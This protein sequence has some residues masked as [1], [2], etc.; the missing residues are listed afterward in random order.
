MP[1]YTILNNDTGLKL[2][3]SHSSHHPQDALLAQFSLY[4]HKSGLS[5]DSFHYYN[6]RLSHDPIFHEL[7]THVACAQFCIFGTCHSFIMFMPKFKK[8]LVN[9]CKYVDTAF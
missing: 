7:V 8:K 9:D 2:L 3:S 5:P 4:V 1:F 6:H